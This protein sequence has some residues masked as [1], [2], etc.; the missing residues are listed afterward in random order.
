[1]Y[2]EDSSLGTV[3][4]RQTKYVTL[5]LFIFNTLL[6]QVQSPPQ[7]KTLTKQT[8]FSAQRSS[9]LNHNHSTPHK[10]SFPPPVTSEPHF[11]LQ[12]ITEI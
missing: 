6:K 12:M 1:M 4:V 2:G 10:A 8:S 9:D 3:P 11:S 5:Q 7:H